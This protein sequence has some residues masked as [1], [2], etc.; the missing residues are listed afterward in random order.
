MCKIRQL[1]NQQKSPAEKSK[2]QEVSTQQDH[3]L[4]PSADNA[5]NSAEVK[6]AIARVLAT[7]VMNGG[8]GSTRSAESTQTIADQCLKEIKLLGFDRYKFVCSVTMGEVRQQAVE[9]VSRCL[10]NDQLDKMV[11]HTWHSN[12]HHCTVTVYGVYH[13]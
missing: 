12:T 10:W 8:D 11:S 2:Q 4:S 13:D 1:L 5:F 6:S 3:Q 7:A 9:L